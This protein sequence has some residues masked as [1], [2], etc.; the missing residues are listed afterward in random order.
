MAEWEKRVPYCIHAFN[1]FEEKRRKN[2]WE[3]AHDEFCKIRTPESY[4]SCLRYYKNKW[5]FYCVIERLTSNVNLVHRAI[6][7][8]N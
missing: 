7:I 1:H 4:F 5:N 2:S 3:P 8:C 6:P